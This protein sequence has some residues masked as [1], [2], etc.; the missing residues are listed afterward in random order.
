MAQNQSWFLLALVG[1]LLYSFTNHIDRV[2][3]QKYFKEGGVGTLIIVSALLSILA[4]PLFYWVDPAVLDVDRKSV[5]ILGGLAL[6]DVILLWSYLLAMKD[7]EPSIVIVFYQL[8]PVL[9]LV[10]GYF[11]LDEVISRMQGIAMAVVLLGTSIVS[12][13]IDGENNIKPRWKTVLFMSI[14]CVCWALELVIFK[15]VALEE[16][17]VRSLFWKHVALVLVGGL[18]FALVPMYR[19]SFMKAI[20]SNSGA[21]MSLNVLN[22]VLYM[23]GTMAVA[24]AAM[25]AQ[26]GLVLLTETYQ[27]IFVFAIAIVLTKYYPTLSEENIES[28]HL[29]QKFL[30]ISVTGVGTYLLLTAK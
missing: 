29:W 11:I 9:G 17:V 4:V 14:A 28:K 13:E 15:A 21:I 26:V 18:I 22:E 5:M 3:L 1:P 27:A 2:L 23:V 12:F 30:A 25:R 7:D 10:F 19:K 20:R 8:V 16:N 6:L 24:F